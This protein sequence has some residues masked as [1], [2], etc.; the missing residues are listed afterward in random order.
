MELESRRIVHTAV[1]LNPTDEWTAQQL[2][3][4]TPWENRPKY[5]IRDNDNKF[6]TKLSAVAKS[7]GIEELKPLTRLRR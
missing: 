7:A 2:R 5:L 3:E 6:G 1:T 4:A